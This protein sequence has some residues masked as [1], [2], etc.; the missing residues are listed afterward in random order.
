M[1]LGN[2]AQI[3]LC[4]TTYI[5][6]Y[7]SPLKWRYNEAYNVLEP[8]EFVSEKISKDLNQARFGFNCSAVQVG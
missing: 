8:K 2:L 3:R 4:L 6:M 7:L 5:L 1:Q